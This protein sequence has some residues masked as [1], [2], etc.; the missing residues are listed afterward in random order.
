MGIKPVSSSIRRWKW[1]WEITGK[2]FLKG[3]KEIN[4]KSSFQMNYKNKPHAKRD[5]KW[6]TDLKS[7]HSIKPR[8]EKEC[9]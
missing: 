9:I 7:L 8:K 4:R 5:K 1:W 6:Y 3:C 2:H